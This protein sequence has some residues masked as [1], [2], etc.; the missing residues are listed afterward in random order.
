MVR[1]VVGLVVF[2]VVGLVVRVNVGLVVWVVDGVVVGLVVGVVD[3]VVDGVDVWLVVL[4]VVRVVVGVVVLV[5]VGVLVA[6]LVGDVVAVVVTRHC[7]SSRSI[8]SLLPFTKFIPAAL[9][10]VRFAV[11]ACGGMGYSTQ[12]IVHETVINY[13]LYTETE[14]NL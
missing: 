14:K 5:I 7:V 12:F 11:Q 4:E 9:Q 6:V 8:T 13:Q 10:A 1:L 3:G 2:D